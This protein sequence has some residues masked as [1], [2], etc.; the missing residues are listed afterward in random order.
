M[1]NPQQIV[2]ALIAN[3]DAGP[4]R[5]LIG[6][7]GSVPG[8]SREHYQRVSDLFGR[9]GPEAAQLASHWKLI[10]RYGDEPAYSYRAR[11]AGE[12][13]EGKYAAAAE[14][15]KQAGRQA[16]DPIDKRSFQTGAV[17]CL[18][19]AG[20]ILEATRLGTKLARELNTLGGQLQAARVRLNLA[21]AL[22]RSDHYK[23][24]LKQFRLAFAVL[25]GSDLRQDT[26][27]CL[28][29]ISSSAVF[30]G[31][32]ALAATSGE[33]A[34][35]IFAEL[36]K[37][38]FVDLC[39]VNM[40]YSA[41]AIGRAD[42]ALSRL[43]ELRPRLADGPEE[44]QAFIDELLGDAY[45]ELNLVDES[46]DCYRQALGR[47]KATRLTPR[48]AN[49]AYGLS[50]AESTLVGPGALPLINRALRMFHR[51]DNPAMAAE[52]HLALARLEFEGGQKSR[53][54]RHARD[55][56][57][58][59]KAAGYKR[60]EAR[61]LLLLTEVILSQNK[62]ALAELARA[63]SLIKSGGFISLE[64]RATFLSASANKA[65][66]RLRIYRQMFQQM[67][68]ARTLTRSSIARSSF[69]SDKS[70]ALSAY[71]EALLSRGGQKDLAEAVD[72]VR[73]SRSAALLDEILSADLPSAELKNELN[74]LREEFQRSNESDGGDSGV[75]RS[76]AAA[77]VAPGF[78]REWLELSRRL[79]STIGFAK[80]LEIQDACVMIETLS[81]YH[82]IESGRHYDFNL[83]SRQLNDHL[84]KIT[85]ELV[86]P[87][88][89]PDADPSAVLKLLG[90]LKTW[91]K[92]P[93]CEFV[94][95]DGLMW[96]VPWQAMPY[97]GGSEEETTILVSPAFGQAAKNYKAPQNAKVVI[98]LNEQ[99]DLPFATA[100]LGVVKS[101]FPSARICRTA[102]EARDSLNENWD[103]LH[104]AAH[105]IH[106]P[107]NPMFSYVGFSDGPLMAAEI[108]NSQARVSCAILLA[109]D[110]GRFSARFPLEPDGLVRAFLSRSA[111]A[112]VGSCWPLNDEAAFRTASEF[113]RV[114]ADGQT[115]GKALS[116]A[117]IVVR[118][119]RAHP[120]FWAAPALFGGYQSS[121][122]GLDTV[123]AS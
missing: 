15:F 2:D 78:R 1:A 89:S 52:C 24:A 48:L 112:V 26:A 95:P 72:V 62:S 36:D 88:L 35:A 65:P 120:Y 57:D 99:D 58:T 81:G 70:H 74:R 93:D 33:T 87:M 90:T 71:F 50:Q 14:S 8:L 21:N 41:I 113:Y 68:D 19:R 116:A 55:A 22:T 86:E 108:V 92:G 49:C 40:A 17:D 79:V 100:E 39:S 16:E 59:A 121:G 114:L 91:L 106:L 56:A 31:D 54:S 85:F 104:V 29:G 98:W 34:Q 75:R 66:A 76:V 20:K 101:I 42:E 122:E 51:L 7:S 28:L 94:V 18:A 63:K 5:R 118:N 97:L 64:W 6:A 38:Y 111:K 53:A 46:R 25:E 82:A 73:K 43:L 32:S 123:R 105:A 13:L 3:T 4:A 27:S 69:L 30:L 67:L 107:D 12:W 37:Q 11:A 119:W 103:I 83:Q 109:C 60:L 23:E 9:R 45:F 10:L 61:S 80:P 110:S 47:L 84:S 102:D 115:V 96:R 44:E 117:R 77:T